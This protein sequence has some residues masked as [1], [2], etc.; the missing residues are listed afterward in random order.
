MRHTV[1]FR[2]ERVGVIVD[3]DGGYEPDTNA[4]DI[5]WHFDGVSPE[6]HDAL[7]LTDE[8]ESAI[9]I[10]LTSVSGEP[11]YFD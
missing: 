9:Y 5:E 3:H 11:D 1:D 4:H 8:E 7:K 2:G 6:E 10:Y